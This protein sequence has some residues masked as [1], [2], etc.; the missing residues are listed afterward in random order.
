MLDNGDAE[1]LLEEVRNGRYKIRVGQVW[2]VP[3]LRG[4]SV[5]LLDFDNIRGVNARLLRKRIGQCGLQP[6]RIQT[7]R[8]PSKKG[9]H[10]RVWI[11]GRLSPVAIVAVQAICESDPAREAQNFRRAMMAD[12]KWKRN[13]NVLY[14]GGKI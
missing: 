14:T 11:K 3:R 10:V 9:L 8:S 7:R 12:P 2:A 4:T 13:W 1:F 6:V 5:V